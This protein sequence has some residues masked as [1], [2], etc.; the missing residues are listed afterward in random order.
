MLGTR[1]MEEAD[2]GICGAMDAKR[3]RPGCLSAASA[4][5]GNERDRIGRYPRPLT[6]ATTLYIRLLYIYIYLYICIYL[7]P[8]PINGGWVGV[9]G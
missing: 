8:S 1:N 2:Y 9:S 7:C 6:L 4:K 3:E 5:R